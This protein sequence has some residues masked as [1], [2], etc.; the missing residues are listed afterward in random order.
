M[1]DELTPAEKIRIAF[2]LFDAGVD[3]MRQSLRRRHPEESP[4]EIQRRL[5]E[6]LYTRP[7]AELGDGPQPSQPQSGSRTA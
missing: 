2:D 1:A 3:M 5:Q 7:G 6:W 4:E